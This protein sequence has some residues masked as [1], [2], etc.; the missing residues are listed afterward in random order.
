MAQT[1]ANDRTVLKLAVY[2]KISVTTFFMFNSSNKYT[3]VV[4]HISYVYAWYV[5][6]SPLHHA[7]VYYHSKIMPYQFCS[8]TSNLTVTMKH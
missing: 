4:R 2:V 3:L 1:F 6:E 8:I 5:A 7:L